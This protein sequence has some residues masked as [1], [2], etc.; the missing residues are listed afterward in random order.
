MAI[1]NIE[2][3]GGGQKSGSSQDVDATW[4]RVGAGS[5]PAVVTTPGMTLT[6]LGF[7]DDP[8]QPSDPNIPDGRIVALTAGASLLIDGQEVPLQVGV[9]KELYRSAPNGPFLQKLLFSEAYVVV[10]GCTRHTC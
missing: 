8:S 1:A 4:V 6:D 2:I 3:V 10:L 5:V 7:D 9:S